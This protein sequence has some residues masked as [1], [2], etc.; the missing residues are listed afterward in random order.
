MSNPAFRF[1]DLFAGIGGFHA[2][3]K[4]F[5][6][7]CVYAVEIDRQ[8]ATVYEANWGHQAFGDITQDADDD[9]GIMNVPAHDVLC[10]GF[11]CQPFS[12]SG[13]QRGMDEAR[14]TLFFNIA[15]IIKTHHPKVVLLENVRNLIG[16][17]HEHEWEVII[18][19]LREEGYN[20]SARPAIFSPHLLPEHLG[21]VPQ[22]RERVFITATY[23][24]D[25]VPR[26]DDGTVDMNA[27]GPPPVATMTDRFPRVAESNAPMFDPG[28]A[29]GGWNLL[30]G[31]LLDESHVIPGCDLTPGETLWI[32]AWDEFAR[33]MSE[34]TSAPLKGFPYW[35][36]SWLDFPEA[37]AAMRRA[38][39]PERRNENGR[40][41]PGSEAVLRLPKKVTRPVID[42]TLPAWKQS[43]LRRN[44]DVFAAHWR[45]ILPWAWRWGVYT[46]LFPASR[47]KLE[48]Q[49]QDAKSLWSTVMHFRPSGI[50]AKRPTYL[51]ALVA[52]TQT[53]IVGPLERRLSP[54]EAARLQGLPDSFIFADQPAA[55]TYRQMGNG[56]AVGAVQHVFREHVLRDQAL[57]AADPDGIGQN[58]VAA[59]K[60]TTPSTVRK[61]L[62][63]HRPAKV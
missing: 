8:A 9:L 53:S 14:G 55:A 54:R 60:G 13:A 2:V 51:P 40:Y 61:R 25:S 33:F 39:T 59:A 45:D 26:N 46:H 7:E 29:E 27:L 35:A 6:G 20:V 5:G 37:A 19:T 30:D 32:D 42:S 17:R 22:V 24:P 10:A 36:D 56:V 44:Y 38:P 52:I 16:P 28:A 31:K 23:G 18:R 3:M 62:A 49:A 4:A 34:R 41:E 12:K 21:G 43:H 63:E 57:L 58:I 48:W 47:R 11:P 50:R 1:I 15:S